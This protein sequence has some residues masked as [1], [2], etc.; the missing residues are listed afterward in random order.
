MPIEEPLFQ[1]QLFKKSLPDFE[2]KYFNFT[3][4]T[5]I[6]IDVDAPL[7]EDVESTDSSSSSD[8][9]SSVSSA[10]P[11]VAPKR[12]PVPEMLADEITGA[13][14]RNMWHVVMADSISN[15][16]RIRTA[17]GRR[18]P[19]SSISVISDLALKPG[20]SLCSHLGCRKGWKAVGAI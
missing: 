3:V 13:L 11:P 14:H 17:C 20:H 10:E 15:S 16:E 7:E 12:R 9:S 1:L 2:W 18:F 8:S 6:P 5:E 19:A 4:Q